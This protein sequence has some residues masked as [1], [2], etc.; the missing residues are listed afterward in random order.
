MEARNERLKVTITGADGAVTVA[1][2]DAVVKV[3]IGITVMFSA[4]DPP[5]TLHDGDSLTIGP[6]QGV[7]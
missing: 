6:L 2:V 4:F 7:S 5:Q 1:E 3:G